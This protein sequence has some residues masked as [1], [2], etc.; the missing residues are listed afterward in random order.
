RLLVGV[1]GARPIL[2]VTAA[3]SSGLAKLLQAGQ[4]P[5]KVRPPEECRWAL[6]ELS[7]YSAGLLENVPA[8][9]IGGAGR[10]GLGAWVRET[11]S[12]LMMT[13]GRN[14]YG[15]GGYYKSP[16]DPLL[17]VSME[18]R[19]EHR[20]LSL[21]MVVALDRSGS[22]LAPVGGGRAKMDLANEG[23]A[24]VLDM[25]GPRD[26]F[27]VLAVDTAAHTIADLAPIKNKAAV[28]KDI[29]SVRSEGGGI[30]IYVAL[31]A[32]VEMLLKAKA[33]TRHIL[34]F[35]DASD[36]EEP[37]EYQELLARCKEAGIT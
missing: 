6:E 7:N 33:G 11:G 26:E 27:G 36:S 2:H 30:F 18:L 29:L 14:S 4:L 37:G 31:E 35:A 34:L 17:P 20:K 12:G 19:D 24:Q 21:A 25:L 28:K 9:K 15:P 23:A 8:E 32:A 13:G 10:E 3:K 1:R 22:M 5:V 16:I